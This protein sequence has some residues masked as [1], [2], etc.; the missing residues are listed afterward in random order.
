MKKLLIFSCLLCI[1]IGISGCTNPKESEICPILSGNF[2]CWTNISW[3]IDRSDFTGCITTVLHALKTQDFTTLA[4]FV[5]PQWLR[6]SPYEYVNATT[7][8]VLTTEEITNGLTIS[9]SYLWWTYDGS[10]EPIDL[11][12]GQFFE[13]FVRD[14]D[15]AQAPEILYNQS[16]QRGNT[17]NNIAQVYKTK[18]WVEFYF[19]WFDPQY[20]GID[21]KSLTLVFENQNGQW[22]LIGIV[23]WS[24]TI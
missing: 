8:V 17:T 21:R 18:Q 7:D 12:I 15:Y 10:G 1:G 9:R 4:Q 24:R 20:S 11:W 14:A 13:K 22:Y 3:S 5:W 19:S 23:H 2:A 6:F 16:I